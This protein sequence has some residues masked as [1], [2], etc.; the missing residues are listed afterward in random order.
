MPSKSG[1]QA[2][3]IAIIRG[4]PKCKV[5]GSTHEQILQKLAKKPDNR[6]HQIFKKRRG[7]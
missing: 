7:M 6:L 5:C 3:S 1:C 4:Q 2:C